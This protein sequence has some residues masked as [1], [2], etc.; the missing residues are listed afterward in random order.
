MHFSLALILCALPLLIE[1]RLSSFRDL[2]IRSPG[3]IFCLWWC[4]DDDKKEKSKE[5]PPRKLP[6]LPQEP[7]SA[8][9]EQHRIWHNS[10]LDPKAYFYNPLPNPIHGR[11]CPSSKQIESD[12]CY[13]KK[14]DQ[15]VLTKGK[16]TLA[17]ATCVY[18]DKTGYVQTLL[19]ASLFHR[20]WMYNEHVEADSMQ[21][22]LQRTEWTVLSQ[23]MGCAV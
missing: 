19:A 10:I 9:D 2:A 18:K 1:A 4:D 8:T 7:P 3:S 21:N 14:N 12:K 17:L 15:P 23:E 6:K 11:I 5:P 20:D 13:S 22:L 16:K